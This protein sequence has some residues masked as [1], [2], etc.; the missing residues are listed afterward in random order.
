LVGV[1][2]AFWEDK[3][4]VTPAEYRR[5]CSPTV[6]LAR[7]GRRVFTTDEKFEAAVEVAHFGQAPLAGA[8]VTW[9]LVG[10]DGRVAARGQLPAQTIPVGNGI[11][12]GQVSVP[13]AALPAPARYRLVV[14]LDGTTVE[15]DWDLWVYPTKLDTPAAAGVV[16]VE[17]LNATARSALA[18][19]GRVLLLIPP[20]RVRNDSQAKVVLGFSS[21][22]WNTAWTRHQPPT[23]LGI[24]CEPQ[25]PAL[26]E[27]PTDA[28]SNWQWWYLISR[29]GA[30]ILDGLPREARPIVQVIDDWFTA[31]KLGLIFEGRV[32]GGRLL[33]CS[34]DLAEGAGANPV[35]RQM[36]HSLLRYMA[37]ERFA[38]RVAVTEEAVARLMTP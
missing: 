8:R 3:G 37:S 17:A 28:H 33:V 2:D 21:I 5:F 4:Y 20:H 24:L 16:V 13:L 19:G 1:L 23:T 31:R 10:D 29:A 11:A 12:L 6:L 34:I 38:P 18:A 9:R 25:H 22:F 15:N 27:F 14:R 30:M 32:Q 35:A 26:A 7:L 36:R